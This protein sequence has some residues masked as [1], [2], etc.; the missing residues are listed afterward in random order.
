[1]S[2][3][4]RGVLQEASRCG[5]ISSTLLD[6]LL[7]P[8]VFKLFGRKAAEAHLERYDPGRMASAQ[9]VLEF[10]DHDPEEENPA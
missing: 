7:T 8:G 6:V 4:S 5:L 1:M 2:P 10:D 9:R 3:A